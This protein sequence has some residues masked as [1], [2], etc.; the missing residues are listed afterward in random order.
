MRHGTTQLNATPEGP[1]SFRGWV[2]VPL[3]PEG[4]RAAQSAARFLQSK[5]IDHVVTS[6]LA[7]AIQ[8]G[9]VIASALKVPITTDQRLRPWNIGYL[10]GQPITPESKAQMNAFQQDFQHAPIPGGEAY[11]DFLAR[12]IPGL[13]DLLNLSQD[14]NIV[15]V[16]HHRN[17]LALHQIIAGKDVQVKGPPHPGGIMEVTPTSFAEVFSPPQRATPDSAS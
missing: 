6:D 13:N 1:G 12:Y 3:A 5:D 15:A 7:R 2:D 11:N 17:A 8:T 16:A 14:S 4:K 10:S 9:R